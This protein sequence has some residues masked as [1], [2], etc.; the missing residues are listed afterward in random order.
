MSNQSIV[1]GNRDLSQAEVDLLLEGRML[2]AQ[3]ARYVE[4]LERDQTLD[5]HW[6]SV[7]KTDLQKGFMCLA[8]A[9]SRPASF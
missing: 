4:K 6:I 5:H 1:H 3:V 9:V 8:R 2:A 7:G